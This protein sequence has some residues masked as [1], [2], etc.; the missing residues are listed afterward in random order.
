MIERY[1][2]DRR[3]E[4]P[5]K[6]PHNEGILLFSDSRT[7]YDED[8]ESILDT[9][10]PNISGYNEAI[11]ADPH[12]E[13]LDMIRDD[14]VNAES[15]FLTNS[16]WLIHHECITDDGLKDDFR[17]AI[18]TT[19]PRTQIYIWI[20]APENDHDDIE[21]DLGE[22][23]ESQNVNLVKSKSILRSNVLNYLNLNANPKRGRVE[24]I[25]WNNNV[26]DRIKA[27][28]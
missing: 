19:P 15:F 7:C 27:R 23:C 14:P 12:G 1:A 22:V 2:E 6:R 13:G 21:D 10:T 3:F 20:D 8:I 11:V 26:H 16:L 24:V 9:V 4:P 5:D 25:K 17:H 18:Q 28:C